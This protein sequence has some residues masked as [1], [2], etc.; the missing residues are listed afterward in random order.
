MNSTLTDTEGNFNLL[1]NNPNIQGMYQGFME[2]S[3]EG[4]LSDDLLLSLNV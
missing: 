4:Y 3:K 2:F 1:V